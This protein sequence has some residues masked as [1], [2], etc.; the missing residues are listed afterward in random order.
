MKHSSTS[1]LPLSGVRVLDLSRIFAGPLCAQVLGD[2]GADV[3]KV[4]HPQR[5]DDT[6]DWGKRIGSTN[7]AYFNSANRNKRSIGV[8]LQTAEGR[9]IVLELAKQSDVLIQNF[10]FGGMKK[11][12]LDYETLKEVNPRLVYC[13]ITGYRTDGPEAARP[14]YDV[15]IQGESGL[16][17]VNG[18]KGQGPLKFGVAAVDMFTGMYSAQAVLAALFDSQRNGKGRHVELALYDCGVMITSYFSMEALLQE[19]DPEKFGNAH[20]SVVPYGVFEAQDGPIVIAVGNNAQ[21]QRFCVDV[22]DRP[23]WASDPRFLTNTAR[24]QHRDVLIPQLN[25]VLRGHRRD[26]LLERLS[27]VGIPCGKVQTLLQALQSE[28]STS[29]G[30]FQDM[31]HPEAGTVPVMAPPYRIDGD[32]APVRAA[33]PMLAED[34]DHILE[35]LLGMN[36]ARIA[37][38]RHTA[39]L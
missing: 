19:Q 34:T 4:E 33:P 5:G 13:S 16:M 25:D 39:V 23:D 28:R 14:G 26:E 12:G 36:S 30:L 31:P 7:T 27:G 11:L 3:I 38:L 15:V 2:L 21:F 32:R 35:T 17:A 20:P 8:N 37:E 18:D 6:R 24:S 9:N 29:A 22:I 1:N 10:K